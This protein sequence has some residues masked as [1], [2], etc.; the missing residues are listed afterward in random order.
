MSELK[1]DEFEID[2]QKAKDKIEERGAE[3]VLLQVPDGLRRKSHK[4]V[5]ELEEYGVEVTLWGGTCYG[6]C[7]LPSDIGDSDILIHIGHSEIPNLNPDYP[8]VYLE[9]RSKRWSEPPKELFEKLEGKVALY[10]S[11]Q[12]MDHLKKIKAILEERGFETVIG[13]GDGR[14][15]YPGQVLGCNY[16]TKVP[17]ADSHLYIGTGRFHPL[18][19]SMS[20]EIEV[21]IF[22]PVTGEFSSTGKKMD[23]LLRKRFAAISS[24]EDSKHVGV[25]LSQK[26]GQRREN[27]LDAL[28]KTNTDLIITEFDEIEPDLVDDFQWDCAVNTA[29]PRIALDDEDNFRTKILTPIEFLICKKKK[30]WD[31]W[32]MDEIH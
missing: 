4:I 22:N 32:K 25:I 8:V 24:V 3:K 11:V 19:L 7:D 29:C 17:D 31:E 12:H 6:A 18:G 16:S 28:D 23:R 14:V 10:A 26:V 15:K 1:L 30:K 9:G 13:E 2:I 27:I 21:F 5:K 20:L